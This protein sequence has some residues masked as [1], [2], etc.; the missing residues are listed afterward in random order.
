MTDGSYPC[1][2]VMSLGGVYAV[3]CGATSRYFA[4]DNRAEYGHLCS[5]HYTTLPVDERAKYEG[6]FW[7]HQRKDLA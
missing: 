4:K 1:R 5:D 7:T 3:R 2:F 6:A